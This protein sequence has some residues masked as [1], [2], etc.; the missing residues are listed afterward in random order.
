[1]FVGVGLFHVVVFAFLFGAK[2]STGV[3]LPMLLFGDV[4]AVG[5]FRQHA[6]WDYVRRM[7][8]PTGLGV[9]AGWALMHS[10][11]E[12]AYKPVIGSII[13]GLAA[14]QAI[15]MTRPDCFSQVPHATWFVWSLGLLSGFSTMLANAAGPIIALYLVAVS[16]PKLELVGTTAWFFLLL[17]VFKIPFSFGL[18]LINLN[19]LSLNAAL[20]PM[21][22]LG[23]FSGRWLIHRIP[24]RLFDSLVLAFS[25]LA[26]L[27]LIGAF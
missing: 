13:L 1:G 25:A 5:A 4:C 16:L 3:V 27:R 2:A 18:G 17:N 10:L 14:M 11:N 15:R 22:V 26:A 6:R 23:L 19:T 8:L 24:Q 7:S 12:S 9:I 21:I 20:T